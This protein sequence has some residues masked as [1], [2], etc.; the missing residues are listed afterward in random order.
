MGQDREFTENQ[1]R[2]V[3][4]TVLAFKEAWERAE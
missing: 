4:E 3:L 1:R 2:F